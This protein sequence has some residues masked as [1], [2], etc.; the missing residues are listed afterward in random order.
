MFNTTPLVAIVGS[1]LVVL[2]DVWF[3]IHDFVLLGNEMWFV[4]MK[5]T[6]LT[7]HLGGL[8]GWEHL[9]GELLG[10]AT[11]GTKRLDRFLV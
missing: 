9:H 2:L 5:T 7:K 11:Q 4:I 3:G 1:C 6:K 10:T 8:V